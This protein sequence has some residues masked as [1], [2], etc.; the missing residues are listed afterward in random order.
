MAPALA[1]QVQLTA[2]SRVMSSGQVA[3]AMQTSMLALF[4]HRVGFSV[5]QD[6]ALPSRQ[7]AEGGLQVVELPWGLLGP[8][9][10]RP[11]QIDG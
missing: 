8:W 10:L 11:L 6:V 1:P 5:G 2:S 7:A 4:L 3:L 9:P